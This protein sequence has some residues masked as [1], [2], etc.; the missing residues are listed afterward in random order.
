MYKMIHSARL[1]GKEKEM[2]IHFLR[3]CTVVYAVWYG[4]VLW[5]P[6]PEDP[7]TVTPSNLFHLQKAR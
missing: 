4:T 2:S 5:G 1:V 3:K 7:C 6:T